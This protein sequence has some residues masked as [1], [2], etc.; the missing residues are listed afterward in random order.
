MKKLI[1]CLSIAV[2]GVFALSVAGANAST[3]AEFLQ[4]GTDIY[5]GEVTINNT[6][7]VNSIKVGK[8]GEGGVTFFNGTIVNITKDEKGNDNPITFGDSVRI[9]GGIFRV[10]ENGGKPVMIADSLDVSGDLLVKGKIKLAKGAISPSALGVKGKI[11]TSANDGKGSGLAADT[12]YKATVAKSADKAKSADSA[13]KAKSADSATNAKNADKVDGLHMTSGK[14]EVRTPTQAEAIAWDKKYDPDV[15]KKVKESDGAMP[16]AH[17]NVATGLSPNSDPSIVVTIKDKKKRND[18]PDWS[19]Q[20][21]TFDGGT[22]SPCPRVKDSSR[23]N[24]LLRDIG[25]WTDWELSW[26]ATTKK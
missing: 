11:W 10:E 14:I 1:L 12:A 7:K 21:V 17:C 6:L 8:E 23:F 13:T 5:N 15:I 19:P 4:P 20:V 25:F 22:G 16:I 24:V 2:V 26:M 3:V 9:D 18:W